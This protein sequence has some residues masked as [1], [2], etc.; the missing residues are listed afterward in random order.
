MGEP[1]A[2][3]RVAGVLVTV[4]VSSI[5]GWRCMVNVTSRS[6][7]VMRFALG[8]AQM[9]AA[10]SAA[11]LLW[12]TGVTA[13]SLVTTLIACSLTALSVL[14]FGSRRPHWKRHVQGPR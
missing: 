6:W 12:R 8:M 14:L 1:S 2:L 3:E 10:T 9:A 11:V 4:G 5:R 13:W 7:G